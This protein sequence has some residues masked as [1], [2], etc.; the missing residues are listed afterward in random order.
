MEFL[1]TTQEFLNIEHILEAAP[2]VPCKDKPSPTIVAINKD[3]DVNEFQGY[4]LS[5]RISQGPS[6]L[7]NAFTSLVLCLLFESKTMLIVGFLTFMTLP[8]SVW[9]SLIVDS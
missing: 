9:L 4:K 3:G 5:A 8:F 7:K 6:L 1:R 2:M